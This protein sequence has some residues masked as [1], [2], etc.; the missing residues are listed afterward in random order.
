MIELFIYKYFIVVFFNP[1]VCKCKCTELRCLH[2]SFLWQPRKELVR[3][4]CILVS[5]VFIMEDVTMSDAPTTAGANGADNQS[6]VCA[7]PYS[8]E[9]ASSFN[10]VHHPRNLL[11]DKPTDMSSRWAPTLADR[12][13]YVLLKFE[14]LCIVRM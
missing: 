5:N 1:S 10:G 4:T 14:T 12:D 11:V 9:G 7:L 8:I 6:L 3:N 13:A 2:L